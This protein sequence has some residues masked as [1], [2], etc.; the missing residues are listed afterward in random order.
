MGSPKD[1]PVSHIGY[2][3]GCEVAIIDEKGKLEKMGA[4][5]TIFGTPINIQAG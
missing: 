5:R 4:E 2:S 3:Y 1:N